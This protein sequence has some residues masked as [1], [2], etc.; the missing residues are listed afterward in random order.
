[1]TFG[2][3]TKEWDVGCTVGKRMDGED[4]GVPIVVSR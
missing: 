1:M 3:T 4:R 2:L